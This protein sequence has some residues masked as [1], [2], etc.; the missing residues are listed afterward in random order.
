V[1]HHGDYAGDDDH[2]DVDVVMQIGAPFAP[3]RKIAEL[4]SARFGVPVPIA[5][6]VRMPCIALMEDG[7]GVQFER[8]GYEHPAAQFVHEG[9]YDT[10]PIQGALGRGRGLNR[11]AETPLEIEVFGNVPLPVPLASLSRWRPSREPDLLA[12]GGTHSNAR[13][14]YRFHPDQFDSEGAAAKWRQ[15]H[16]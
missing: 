1:L 16:P 9:I 2:G 5:K 7:I 15:R 3:Y 8:M 14:L 11:T 12:K 10:S 4:A 6:P 13:D